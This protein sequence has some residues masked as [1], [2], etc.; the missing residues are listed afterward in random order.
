M[1][2]LV[3]EDEADL[4]D[5]LSFIL[6]RAG[7]EVFIAA[8][9]DSALRVWRERSPELVLLDIGLPCRTGWEVCQTIR[10][11][12]TTPVMILSGADTEEDIVR[13]LDLGAEDYV[14]KPFSPRLLQARIKTVLRR[15]RASD[16]GRTEATVDAGD[17]M[18]N[19]DWHT[20]SNQDRSVRLTRLEHRVLQEL[21]LHIGQVVPHDELIEKVWGY[22]GETS[23][24]ILKGHIRNLRLKLAHLD[25]NTTIRIMPGVGYVLSKSPKPVASQALSANS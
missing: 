1:A 24:N 18:L 11:E 2:I 14:T 16:S 17:L 25:S 12:S 19:Q 4:S 15:S 9:G 21:A 6:R 13:G 10:R 7:H 3:V 23:S 8:D 20:V 5:L 22:T